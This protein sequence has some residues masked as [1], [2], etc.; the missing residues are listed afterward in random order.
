MT[1]LWIEDW[2]S[3]GFP[4]GE[5]GAELA[6]AFHE[7]GVIGWESGPIFRPHGSRHGTQGVQGFSSSPILQPDSRFTQ[8]LLGALRKPGE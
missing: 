3:A 4:G 2:V 6:G 7:G 5:L 1:G 8:L